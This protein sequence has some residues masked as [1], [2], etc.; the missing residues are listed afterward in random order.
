MD[1]H[2]YE[3]SPRDGLQGMDTIV[4]TID[5]LTLID[6]I[7]EAGINRIEVGSLV[8]PKLVPN[9][10]DSDVVFARS[11]S[12]HQNSELGVLIPNK[13]GMERAKRIG[14]SNFNIFMS[15]SVGFNK[16]NH[17]NT[18]LNVFREYFDTL[19]GVPRA[20]VRVYL[21]CAF[22]CP[23]DGEIS[24]EMLVQSLMWAGTF[25]KTIVLSDT[26]G[27]ATGES[28]RSVIQTARDNGITSD[29]ALHLHYGANDVSMYEKLDSAYEMGVREFDSCIMGLGGCP[30]VT[31]SGGNLS[32]SE[33][34]EWSAS[35]LLSCGVDIEDIVEVNRFVKSKF[36]E[37]LALTAF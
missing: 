34:V 19:R 1:F 20:N 8:H 27:Q 32:T 17:N 21:S 35:R 14:V 13:K 22:G 26:A 33:L 16:N 18:P 4:P 3:V 11:A 12:K 2:I 30:F 36:K 15:P 10:A 25:G 28:I 7:I 6:L 9:M 29:M 37:Q 31:G 23:M 5:K 24:E